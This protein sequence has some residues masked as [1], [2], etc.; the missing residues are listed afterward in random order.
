MADSRDAPRPEFNTE[1]SY[2]YTQAPNKDWK[3]GQS[4]NES[5]TS[6]IAAEWAKGAEAGYQT[7]VPENEQ[8]RYVN[9]LH[10]LFE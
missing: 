5:G 10:I 3:I 1:P 7:F 6:A 4:F 9:T 2:R 8:P